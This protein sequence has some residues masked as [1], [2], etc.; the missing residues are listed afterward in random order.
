MDPDCPI[1]DVHT[2]HT[3]GYMCAPQGHTYSLLSP[4]PGTHLHPLRPT[5]PWCDTYRCR[6]RRSRHSS[7]SSHRTTRSHSHVHTRHLL[8]S[9]RSLGQTRTVVRVGDFTSQ[10]FS[11][12]LRL[13]RGTPPTPRGSPS[14][15]AR[16]R[17]GSHAELGGLDTEDPFSRRRRSF[18]GRQMRSLTPTEK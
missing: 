4:T 12:E 14:D 13:D 2:P 11:R 1:R 16:N 9:R 18:R 6:N 5:L 15:P 7:P 3:Q 10:A 17:R 8:G